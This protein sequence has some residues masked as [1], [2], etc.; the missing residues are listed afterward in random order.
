MIR[1]PSGSL[2]RLKSEG[3][4]IYKCVAP[5]KISSSGDALATLVDREEAV[6]VSLRWENVRF[7]VE[8]DKKTKHILKGLSGHAKTGEMLAILGPTGCG[9]TSLLNVLAARVPVTKAASLTGNITINGQQRDESQFRKI[10][11]YVLQDD[12]M[13]PH[14]TVYETLYLAAQFFI[15]GA[16]EE[17]KREAIVQSV[18]RDLGLMS[19]RDTMIGDE[20]VRGVSGGER[21]RTSIG[22]QLISNPQVFFLDEPTSGLDSFQAQSVMEAMGAL[23]R[24]GKL[25]ISVIHQPRSSVFDMFDRLLLLSEGR[26]IYEGSAAES[27][28]YFRSRGFP[29]PELFNPSDFYLDLTSPDTRTEASRYESAARIKQLDDLWVVEETLLLQEAAKAEK[30]AEY[31][32]Y[33]VPPDNVLTTK[34]F[35]RNLQLLCWRTISEQTREISTLMIRLVV[36]IVFSLIIAGMYSNVGYTQ[37]AIANRTGLL[38]VISINQGFN[39]LIA[40][41]N[42]F[43]KE[44]LIVSR[45]RSA[46]AYDVLSY[47]MAKF[48]C[49]LPLNVLPCV[50]FGSILYFIVGLNPGA[51]NFFVFL[52]ALMLEASTAIALG[53]VVSAAAP[54]VEAA[55]DFGPLTLIIS[56]LF[57]GFF[58][59]LQS[60]PVVAEWLPNLSFLRWTFGSLAVNEF[61]GETFTCEYANVTMCQTTGEQVLD[62][63]GF[64]DGVEDQFFGLSMMFVGF[65]V[66]AVI[67]LAYNGMHYMDIHPST[68]AAAAKDS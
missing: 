34:R 33:P 12:L 6:P 8:E 25:V 46:N 68:D 21:K 47:F 43:P 52:G 56:L 32:S 59:N 30:E 31:D 29:C 9:K 15:S 3:E 67:T 50:V 58:I 51:G 53:L 4:R 38:F 40:V 24:T 7:S 64:S 37:K 48:V 45:E 62:R 57:G 26:T 16:V 66:L 18:M 60:L 44:K 20:R 39:A 35:L 10:S 5:M 22:V 54:T 2:N 13:Y 41:L 14:L 1:G 27:S 65:F 11:A 55:I 36:T 19:C 49:E 17:E 63:L 23:A 28:E 42:V 61:K